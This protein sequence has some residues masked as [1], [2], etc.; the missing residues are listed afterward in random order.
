MSTVE[1]GDERLFEVHS[2]YRPTELLIS[3]F[4]IGIL[5]SMHPVSEHYCWGEW[6]PGYRRCLQLTLGRYR[7]ADGPECF[8]LDIFASSRCFCFELVGRQRGPLGGPSK[9]QST[10][11]LLRVGR[12]ED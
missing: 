12:G 8:V 11:W 6:E 2:S 7:T 1:Q 4:S 3:P 9:T 10:L 5:V